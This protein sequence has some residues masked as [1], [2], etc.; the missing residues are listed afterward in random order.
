MA[1]TKET[2]LEVNHLTKKFRITDS[3]GKK[4]DLIAVNDVSFRVN[5]GEIYGI[6][7]ESGCGKST[8]GRCVLR[9]IEPTS[10]EVKYHGKDITKM[11]PK[12]MKEIRKS[13]QIVFQN[14]YASF[15][16]RKRIGKALK[17]VL[18]H[19]GLYQGKEDKR[20]LEILKKVNLGSDALEKYPHQFSGGQLQR[21]AVARA[22]LVEPEII[23]ADEPVSALDV[24]VQAQVVNLLMDLR[25]EMGLTIIFIAHDLSVVEHISDRAGVMY[26]GHFVEESEIADLYHKPMHP[27]TK[28]LLSAIPVPDP[29]LPPVQAVLDGETAS[30]LHLPDGCIF[31]S[32]CYRCQDACNQ[33]ANH[34]NHG[35]EG[36]YCSCLFALQ[37]ESR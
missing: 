32:R 14:P 37:E 8:L 17:E 20:I 18:K 2:I 28:G 22:L 30:P 1:E 34:T 26:V 33:N 9:L 4:H 16:P 21:L 31:A 10:G 15:N 13:I 36:H 6:V 7:G 24:S 11:K 25:D 29:E 3:K 5:K 23:I 35:T 12:E 19:F 27:Y